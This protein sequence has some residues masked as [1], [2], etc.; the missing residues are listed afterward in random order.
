MARL[1]PEF[2]DLKKRNDKNNFN[3]N[4]KGILKLSQTHNELKTAGFIPYFW[5]VAIYTQSPVG[6]QQKRNLP[7]SCY[8]KLLCPICMETIVT[9]IQQNV[10]HITYH[11]QLT[12]RIIYIFGT[13]IKKKKWF[14]DVIIL[15]CIVIYIQEYKL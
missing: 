5:L 3:Q 2:K 12:G 14:I 6:V 8:K 10:V 13:K 9:A 15:K 7:I 4:L 11:H 1:K